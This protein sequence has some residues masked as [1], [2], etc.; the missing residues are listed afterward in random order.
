MDYVYICVYLPL[1]IYI[2]IKNKAL[3]YYTNLTISHF[4]ITS[5]FRGSK[6]GVIKKPIDHIQSIGFSDNYLM[7]SEIV[8]LQKP[9][10]PKH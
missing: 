7:I 6:D 8:I 10:I 3:P 5:P 9:C 4:Q 1:Q 2:I